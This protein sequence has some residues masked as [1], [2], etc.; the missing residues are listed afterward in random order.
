MTLLKTQE[1]LQKKG[2]KH[3]KEYDFILLD[4]E[5]VSSFIGKLLR[6][7]V[8]IQTSN[9]CHA[10]QEVI[11]CLPRHIWF[12][13]SWC[14]LKLKERPIH[15]F[16]YLHYSCHV[17]TAVTIIRSTE[18]RHNVF[19][20]HHHKKNLEQELSAKIPLAANTRSP[21]LNLHY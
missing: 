4:H 6:W 13:L 14:W 12:A 5:G 11:G 7:R 9:G 8:T 3:F 18:N 19:V 1:Q 16:I 21:T 17:P 20:L 15:L 2:G 10:L